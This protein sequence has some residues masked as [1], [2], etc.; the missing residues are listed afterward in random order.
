MTEPSA[1]KPEDVLK[2]LST[3]ADPR[4]IRSLQII[5]E[6][7]EAQRKH[8]SH[9]Y[10]LTRIGRQS[11]QRGG[12]STAALGNPSGRAYRLLIAAHQAEHAVPRKK[13]RRHDADELLAGIRDPLQRA[14][15]EQLRDEVRACRRQV[16]DLQRIAN[17]TARVAM[18][19]NGDAADA[20]FIAPLSL[21]LLPFER[22]ALLRALDPQRL[23]RV[24]LLVEPRGRVETADGDE[25][26]PVG[27]A[28]GLQKLLALVG[29]E[30][31]GQIGGLDIG[32]PTD[33]SH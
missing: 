18:A 12:P 28:T 16:I 13:T 27:F 21:G 24:G 23:Q 33:P 30:A 6:V 2:R 9:D 3:G 5:H 7:C 29:D 19:K 31:A 32:G 11:Q 1:E 25:L 26:F 4:R 14:R 10:S 20:R 17:G 8:G 15:I 22:D